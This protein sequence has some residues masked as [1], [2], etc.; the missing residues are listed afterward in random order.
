MKLIFEYLYLYFST[1]HIQKER[2]KESV[3]VSERKERVGFKVGLAD[4][5]YKDK[6]LNCRYRE[7]CLRER[8]KKAER[9]KN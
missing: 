8:D 9:G 6:N 1:D 7:N 3:W 5:E 4:T 2:E